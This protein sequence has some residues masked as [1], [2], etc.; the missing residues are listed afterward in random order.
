[1][2][3]TLPTLSLGCFGKIPSFGDFVARGTGS[4]CGRA[5]ERWLQLANDRLAEASCT[6]PTGPVGF[7]FRDDAAS[8]LLVGTLS[9]SVD[10]VGRRFPLALF[11]S[12]A[13]ATACGH[14]RCRSRWHPCSSSS[15]A[16][17][18]GPGATPRPSSSR[19]STRWRCPPRPRSCRR[20]RP[21]ARDC[22]P[23]PRLPCSRACSATSTRAATRSTCCC[24]PASRRGALAPSR[25]HWCWIAR[26]AATSS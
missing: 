9:G 16:S 1:M 20:A 10:K 24:G 3:A 19:S 15:A 23:R 25:R 2:S 22:T 18:I 6:A 8:S 7:V 17:R 14:R 12:W 26:W 13:A 5:F 4:P 21:S 11:C